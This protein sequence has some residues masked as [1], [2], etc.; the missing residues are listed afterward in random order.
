M[1]FISACGGLLIGLSIYQG[2]FDFGIPQFRLAFQPVLIALAASVALVV[3]RQVGGRGAALGAVA[4]FIV[5]RGLLSVFVGPV[6]GEVTPH[7]P[8][9]LAEGVIVELVALAIGTTARTAS[10]SSPAR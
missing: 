4:F 3:A 8:L 7:L 5:V 10:R 9:Y 1:R 6:M 2:E